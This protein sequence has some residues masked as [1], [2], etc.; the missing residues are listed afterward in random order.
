[1]D[2]LGASTQNLTQNTYSG[3]NVIS[4]TVHLVLIP[5]VYFNAQRNELCLHERL[6]PCVL[7]ERGLVFT[8]MS[9]LYGGSQW[10][11]EI[12]SVYVMPNKNTAIN[13]KRQKLDLKNNLKKHIKMT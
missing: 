4:G 11:S 9:C 13:R 2:V 3:N 10:D 7:I 12:Y 6:S 5:V 1:M 8:K